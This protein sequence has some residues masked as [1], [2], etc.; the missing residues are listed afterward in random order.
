M[1]SPTRLL[2]VPGAALPA[3]HRRWIVLQDRTEVSDSHLSPGPASSGRMGPEL[4]LILQAQ[5]GQ[6]RF[7]PHNA[8]QNSAVALKAVLKKLD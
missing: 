6:E 2:E 3:T 7:L 1:L 4:F 8:L 5:L